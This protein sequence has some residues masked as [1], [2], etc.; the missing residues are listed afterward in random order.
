VA[1]KLPRFCKIARRSNVVGPRWPSHW[2]ASSTLNFGDWR[3]ELCKG[4]VAQF[5]QNICFSV[6]R[7]GVGKCRS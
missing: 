6:W 5:Q 1:Q 7:N 3:E 4:N 2:V